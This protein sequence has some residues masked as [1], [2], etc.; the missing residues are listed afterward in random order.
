MEPKLPTTLLFTFPDAEAC[1][2][3]VTPVRRI[4]VGGN[5]VR[6]YIARRGCP[7]D[8]VANTPSFNARVKVNDCKW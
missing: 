7:S 6:K 4:S 8:P 3:A 2:P 1:T 5:I